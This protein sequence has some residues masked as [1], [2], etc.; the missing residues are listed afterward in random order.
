MVSG[1]P[2]TLW[3]DLIT[4]ALP[5]LAAA[6]DV[7]EG[8]GLHIE[9]INERVAN[10][11][12]LFLRVSLP[13][14]FA[15]KLLFSVHTD[16]FHPHVFGKHVHDLIAFVLAQQTVVDKNTGELVANG[17]VQQRCDHG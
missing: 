4:W 12:A 11:F 15:Q 1:R 13:H 14:Q 7:F 2:P 16:D 10:D 17:L 5:V 3:W 6:V 8:G 9:N